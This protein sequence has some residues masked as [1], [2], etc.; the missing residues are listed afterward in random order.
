MFL[1]TSVFGAVQGHHLISIVNS[2]EKSNYIHSLDLHC[3]SYIWMC[4]YRYETICSVDLAISC[5]N[6][7][8][9]LFI[10]FNFGDFAFLIG[11]LQ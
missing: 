6:M 8:T 10:Y 1:F 2:K 4:R 5:L 11:R 7:T 3:L 9:S